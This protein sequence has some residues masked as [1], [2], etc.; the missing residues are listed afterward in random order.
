[1]SPVS[2]ALLT[3]ALALP[4]ASAGCEPSPASGGP[5]TVGFLGSRSAP[6]ELEVLVVRPDDTVAPLADGGGVSLMLPPQGGRVVFVGARATNVDGC[7]LQLTGALRDATP[8][9]GHVS[10]DVRTINLT[11]TGDGWGVSG[12]G[13][14]SASISSFANIPA[15]PNNWSST[16]VFGQPYQ[17]ELTIVDRE[18]RTATRSLHVTPSCDQPASA[19]EGLGPWRRRPRRAVEMKDEV[20]GG[21]RAAFGR[22][23]HGP[24]VA[25]ARRPHAVERRRRDAGRDLDELRAVVVRDAPPLAHGPDVRRTRAV[26]PPE[27]LGPAGRQVAPRLA[28]EVEHRGRRPVAERTAHG[29]DVGG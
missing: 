15:C 24:H 18:G 22:A 6:P 10:V 23:A 17:V 28:V 21:A 16:D 25:R 2:P 19:A 13:V 4:L 9:R 29:E 14:V 7:G 1:M 11:P 3:L 12:A 5:C 26:H 8:A 20:V 27:R